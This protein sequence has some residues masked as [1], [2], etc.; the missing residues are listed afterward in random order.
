MLSKLFER[1]V[2]C[3]NCLEFIHLLLW[4]VENLRAISLLVF[5]RERMW[6]SVSLWLLFGREREGKRDTHKIVKLKMRKQEIIAQKL[7]VFRTFAYFVCLNCCAVTVHIETDKT[8]TKIKNERPNRVQGVCMFCWYIFVCHRDVQSFLFICVVF[9]VYVHLFRRF[10]FQFC[11]FSFQPS[12]SSSDLFESVYGSV[13]SLGVCVCIAI[14]Q[15][16]FLY[17]LHKDTRASKA[18]HIFR[19]SCK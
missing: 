5:M 1:L 15:N 10:F 17:G 6:E 4:K 8:T 12:F 14:L 18:P 19:R 13:S 2:Y 9:C 16:L 7:H 11:C 3:L